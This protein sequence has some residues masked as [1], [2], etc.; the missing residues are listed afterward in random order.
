MHADDRRVPS[1]ARRAEK[2]TIERGRRLTRAIILERWKMHELLRGRAGMPKGCQQQRSQG[3]KSLHGW[4][5]C[6]DVS[7]FPAGIFSCTAAS[8]V[9]D[10]WGRQHRQ[11]GV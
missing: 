8:G 1:I 10:S 5:S 6:S 2:I 3:A 7:S 11:E 4:I 9:P